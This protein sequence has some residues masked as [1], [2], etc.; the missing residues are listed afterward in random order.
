M[1]MA[2][3]AHG[4]AKLLEQINEQYPNRSRD[5]DGWIGDAAHRARKSDHNPNPAGVVIGHDFT[6]DPKGGFDAYKFA[7]HL[8]E[9]KDPRLEYVITNGR[10]FYSGGKVPWQWQKYGGSN[11]HRTHVHISLLDDPKKHDDGS[12]WKMP[13][14]KVAGN[15]KEGEDQKAEGGKDTA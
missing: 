15:D 7:E 6:H 1:S 3:R 14:T 10:I 13:A 9:T 11:P 2:R 8:R 12:D 5:S 4:Q